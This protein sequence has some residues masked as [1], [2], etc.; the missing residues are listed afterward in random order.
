MSEKPIYLSVLK[1]RDICH[2]ASAKDFASKL[3]KDQLESISKITDIDSVVRKIEKASIKSHYEPEPFIFVFVHPETTK[4]STFFLIFTT[5]RKMIAYDIKNSKKISF[6]SKVVDISIKS[7]TKLQVLF[8]S[9]LFLKFVANHDI[10]VL[11]PYVRSL[12]SDNK[13]PYYEFLLA[14]FSE[15]R[16]PFDIFPDLRSILSPCLFSPTMDFVFRSISSDVNGKFKFFLGYTTFSLAHSAG[17]F[18]YAFTN[19]IRYI[20]LQYD[21]SEDFYKKSEFLL[22]FLQASIDAFGRSLRDGCTIIAPGYRSDA[23]LATKANILVNFFSNFNFKQELQYI[24]SQLYHL[25]KEKYGEDDALKTCSR[26]FLGYFIKHLY[27]IKRAKIDSQNDELIKFILFEPQKQELTANQTRL[28]EIIRKNFDTEVEYPNRRSV[29]QNPGVAHKNVLKVFRALGNLYLHSFDCYD[30]TKY[31]P[32]KTFVQD[33]IAESRKLLGVQPPPEEKPKPEEEKP[34]AEEQKP[35]TAETKPKDEE[36]K[37]KA[38]ENKPEE[39]KPKSDEEKPKEEEEKPKP[40]EQKP[41]DE[42]EKPS[43][44]KPKPKPEEKPKSDENKPKD[45]SD[46]HDNEEKSSSSVSYSYSKSSSKK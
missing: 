5:D 3:S 29:S 21:N 35:E 44:D 27:E 11:E 41:K 16:Y 19:I 8:E 26:Y 20:S 37:P 18:A 22:P 6:K 45:D 33:I 36:E 23:D 1:P 7:K 32:I 9:K 38:E 10:D 2:A 12:Y 30:K 4:E 42:A 25:V 24:G 15:A 39:E 13:P 46:K 17:S 34:K 28:K 31:S 14:S 43:E 40:D